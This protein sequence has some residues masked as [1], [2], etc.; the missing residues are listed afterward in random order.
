VLVYAC[1]YGGVGVRRTGAQL[2]HSKLPVPRSIR[3]QEDAVADVEPETAGRNGRKIRTAT[4]PLAA[5]GS[6]ALARRLG[7]DLRI[8]SSAR[9]AVCRADENCTQGAPPWLRTKRAPMCYPEDD[10]QQ[11]AARMR[12]SVHRQA[13]RRNHPHTAH[14]GHTIHSHALGVSAARTA[15]AATAQAGALG[16]AAAGRRTMTQRPWPLPAGIMSAGLNKGG[17]PLEPATSHVDPSAHMLIDAEIFYLSIYL[18]IYLSIYLS[19][20]LC[21]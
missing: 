17:S 18:P 13:V 16:A 9:L 12:P 2:L 1:D 11:G 19:I 20:Y 4:V 10:T 15:H 7:C 14:H 8:P 3:V 6:Q 5:D 21:I